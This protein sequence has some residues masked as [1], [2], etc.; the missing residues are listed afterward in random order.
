M[1]KAGFNW[2]QPA[3][4]CKLIWECLHSIVQQQ[5]P[6]VC[7]QFANFDCRCDWQT[8]IML[9]LMPFAPWCIVRQVY[10]GIKMNLQCGCC[11][12]TSVVYLKQHPRLQGIAAVQRIIQTV[13]AH[14]HALVSSF[15]HPRGR[16]QL[17]H[18]IC[19]HFRKVGPLQS[20][21]VGD[22]IVLGSSNSS[23][24]MC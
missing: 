5:S 22:L 24:Y 8:R 19:L 23:C 9:S 15:C 6:V 3:V 13:L 21:M 4:R 12:W 14:T 17:E 16:A 7:E 18:S 2:S 10:V 1:Q 20:C 11:R